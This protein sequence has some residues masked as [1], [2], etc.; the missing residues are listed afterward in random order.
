MLGMPINTSKN[1]EMVFKCQLYEISQNFSYLSEK[2]HNIFVPYTF[3]KEME[4]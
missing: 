3:K 4:G 2:L 1:T